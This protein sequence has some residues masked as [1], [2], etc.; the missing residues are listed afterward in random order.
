[1]Y[2]VGL[3]EKHL[4]KAK[5]LSEECIRLFYRDE[6]RYFA[7]TQTA[8][9]VAEKFDIN[10]DVI[11]SGNSIM[12]HNLYTLSWYF[13]K[14][15]WRKMS[16]DMLLGVSE[17]LR[18]SGP[19]YSHWAALSLRTETSCIQHLISSESGAKYPDYF[20][21]ITHPNTLFGYI[22]TSTEIPLFKGKEYKDKNLVYRCE[23]KTCGLPI[24]F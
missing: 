11:S 17:L 6:K 2:Q 21:F 9:V 14:E 18:K 15:D 22:G 23:N 7:F 8:H 20:S 16:M 13:D 1:L 12:A 10:D 4:L 5:A 19:W 24:K 3:N